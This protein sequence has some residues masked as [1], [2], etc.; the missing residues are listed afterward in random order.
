MALVVDAGVIVAETCD[1]VAQ[2]VETGTVDDCEVDAA[3]ADVGEV[4]EDFV[5]A[6]EGCV[7]AT[8]VCAV[9]TS[10][11]LDVE[12]TFADE[13]EA[14]VATVEPT[15]GDGVDALMAV[16]GDNHAVPK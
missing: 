4:V 9:L 6:V 15:P 8:N 10:V 7:D 11:A 2:S 5:D 1:V 12:T 3:L 16:A 13:I 14:R